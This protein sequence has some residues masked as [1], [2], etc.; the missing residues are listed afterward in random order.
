MRSSSTAH[1]WVIEG[2][3][4]PVRVRRTAK[5]WFPLYM[6]RDAQMARAIFKHLIDLDK[7]PAEIA[8]IEDFRIV[9]PNPRRSFDAARQEARKR[10]RSASQGRRSTPIEGRP[11]RRSVRPSGR[12]LP[13]PSAVLVGGGRRP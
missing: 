4:R 11:L 10:R 7:V 9:P 5:R 6:Y 13:M 8:N 2:L 1:L 3:G 12:S